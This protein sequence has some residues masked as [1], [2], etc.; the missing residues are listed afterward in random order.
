MLTD[1]WNEVKKALLEIQGE[2]QAVPADPKIL[3]KEE[4]A[5]EIVRRLATPPT[6]KLEITIPMIRK[7]LPSLI[8]SEIL[9]VQPMQDIFIEN[10]EDEDDSRT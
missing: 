5:D 6:P 2:L 8:A 10:K 4:E 9:S 3:T 1:N 7:I